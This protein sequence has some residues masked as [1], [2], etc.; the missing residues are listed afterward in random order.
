M[1]EKHQPYCHNYED[2]SNI[3]L[4]KRANVMIIIEQGA[5]MMPLPPALLYLTTLHTE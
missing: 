5:I 2:N 4:D 3:N 1:L